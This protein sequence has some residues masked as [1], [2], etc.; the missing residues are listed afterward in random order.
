MYVDMQLCLVET[1]EILIRIR[2][3]SA[4]DLIRIIHPRDLIV[5]AGIS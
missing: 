4:G 3:T 5:G 1:S 2:V